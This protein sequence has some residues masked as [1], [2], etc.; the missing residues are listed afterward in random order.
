[1]ALKKASSKYPGIFINEYKNGNVAYYINY[2]NEEGTPTLKKVGM[3]TKQSNY[4][5]MDAYDRLIEVKHKIATGEELPKVVQRKAKVL[6]EDI[7]EDYLNWAK[8]NKKTWKHNDLL[9]YNKHLSYLAKSDPRT[10]KPKDFEELKQR[11]LIEVDKKLGRVLAPK[12]V[13]HI[14]ATARHI[15]NHAIKNELIKNL[16]N[17]IGSGRVRMPKVENQKIGFFTKEK[18]KELLELLLQRENKRLYELT[19]LLLFTGA[20]FS[21]VA[22]LT[23]SDINFNTSLIFFASSKDGNARYIKMSNRVLEVVNTLYKNKINNLVIPTINGNK[24]E[25]MPK[26]WQIE[27]D[28]LIPGNDNANKDRLTTH[29]LRHSHA[30]WLAQSGVDIL[31]IKEQLGHKKIETTMRYSHLIDDRRHQAT[32][33][34]DF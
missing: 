6:F 19:T 17:P 28:K 32:E 26:E 30:S 11:K 1:M 14:L 13:Q 23:W 2:R 21:E 34:L 7:F 20:R 25:K 12:T 22:R 3:K 27:V 8:A 16:T 24:Y 15:F 5:I 29:S 9:V 31:H 33:R 4:T 18:A 10:L